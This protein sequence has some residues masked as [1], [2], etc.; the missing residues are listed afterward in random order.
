MIAV[1]TPNRSNPNL[2][3]NGRATRPDECKSKPM[4]AKAILQNEA[5]SFFELWSGIVQTAR[6]KR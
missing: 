3:L 4:K 6:C 2:S 1:S 5:V